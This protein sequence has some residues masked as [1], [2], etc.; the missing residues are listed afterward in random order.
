MPT[1]EDVL[2]R[3]IRPDDV[4]GCADEIVFDSHV[5]ATTDEA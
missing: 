3:Q 2:Q 4:S 5:N 1:A